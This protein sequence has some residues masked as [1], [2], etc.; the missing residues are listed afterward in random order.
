MEES[1]IENG[2]NPSNEPGRDVEE[3]LARCVDRLLD[4]DGE[5]FERILSSYPE[6]APSLRSRLGALDRVGLLQ[7]SPLHPTPPAIGHYTILGRLGQGGMSLVWLARDERASRLVALKTC[8]PSLL[9]N[10]RVRARFEREIRAAASLEHPNIVSM[11]DVGEE[12]GRPFFTMEYVAGATLAEVLEDL[13]GKAL[14]SLTGASVAQAV[15]RLAADRQDAPAGTGEWSETYV[16]TVCRIVLDVA[17]A[18]A[19]AHSQ[20]VVHRDVKPSNIMLRAGG[21]AQ[22]FDFGLAHLE[23]QPALTRSGDFTGTPYYVSPEQL[24]G[25]ARE[26]DARTDVY[27][28][29]V[30]LYELLA[31]GRPFEGVGTVQ[32]LRAIQGRE[33]IALRRRNPL[34]PRD[35]ETICATAM[36]KDP[37]RRY[38]TMDEMAADLRRLLAFQPVHARPTGALLRARRYMRRRPALAVTLGAFALAAVGLP[39][40]LLRVNAVIRG[41]RDRAEFEGRVRGEV[42]EF[43]VDHFRRLAPEPTI[44]EEDGTVSREARRFLAEGAERLAREFGDDSLARAALMQALGLVY[45]DVGQCERALPLLDRAFAVLQREHGEEHADVALVLSTLGAAHFQLGNFDASVAICRRALEAYQAIGAERTVEALECRLHLARGAFALGE[46]PAAE[47]ELERLL[48]LAEEEAVAGSDLV[49]RAREELG[50]LAVERGDSAL[51][52]ERFSLALEERRRL[53]SPDPVAEAAT[54]TIL[55]ELHREQGRTARATALESEA[56]L[57]HVGDGA[58]VAPESIVA[59]ASASFPFRFERPWESAEDPDFQRG[60]TALQAGHYGAAIEAFEQCSDR[61]PA[62]PI[63]SLQH[64]SRR[65]VCAYN[66]ACAH[67]LL[68]E[69]DDGRAWLERAADL[70][71][72]DSEQRMQVVRRDKDLDALRD[73]AWWEHLFERMRERSERRQRYVATAATYFPASFRGEGGLPLLVILHPD[74]GTKESAVLGPWKRLADELGLALLAPSGTVQLKAEPGLGMAW[75]DDLSRFLSDPWSYEERI[76]ECVRDFTG[77]E[78]DR[79]RVVLA[80]QGAGATIA[81]DLALRAPRLFRGVLVVDGPIHPELGAE[82][83]RTAASVGLRARVVLDLSDP[84]PGLSPGLTPEEVRRGAEQWLAGR[85]LCTNGPA[86]AAW[87]SGSET[88]RHAALRDALQSLLE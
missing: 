68:G 61:A 3:V 25:S 50:R 76:A 34:V 46:S 65:A 79:S 18:L 74:G 78:I 41:E 81:F 33:P 23:D 69:L 60:I 11:F 5:G 71:F 26:V 20:G 70:G 15:R 66:M 1:T 67:T 42:I 55:A 53:W 39:L 38:A 86:V 84:I 62:N 54:L 7:E 9:A 40:G 8:Q 16:E 56:A 80:G 13:S 14:E 43:L 6:H 27:S 45:L 24:A 82:H 47:V 52:L 63:G 44:D 51:A 88:D 2:G 21:R 22:L 73:S 36:E 64:D 28:L 59:T 48:E 35:L 37:K 77:G 58:S 57:L 19:Y 10:E 31:L 12:Q 85:G 49:P 75:I 87:D 17:D 72:G 32:V 29:G 83:V 30:T 4:G